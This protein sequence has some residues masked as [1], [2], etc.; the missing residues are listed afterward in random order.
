MEVTLVCVFQDWSAASPR[1][2]AHVL[3][4]NGAKNLYRVGFEGMVSPPGMDRLVGRVVKA[5]ASRAE[6]P[7]V[8]IL[9]APGFFGVESYQ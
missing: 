6:G 7:R 9:L 8:R 2:A 4:D 3:W 5:S 1:S